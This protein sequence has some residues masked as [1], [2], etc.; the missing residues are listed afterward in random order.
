MHLRKPRVSGFAPIVAVLAM[1]T[2]AVAA[3]RDVQIRTIDF[4]TGVI[5]L[6][7]FGAASQ[8][9]NGFVFCTFDDNQ[10][11][12]YTLSSGLNGQTVAAGASLFIHTLN[13]APAMAGHINR[14]VLGGAMAAPLDA[15]P[16]AMSFYLPPASFT[17]PSHMADHVQWNVGG[18]NVPGLSGRA[19]VAVSAGLW[20]STT[21]WASTTATSTGLE[22]TDESGGLG[23]GPANY[24]AIEDVMTG[25]A[26]CAE[27]VC[28]DVDMASECVPFVCNVFAMLPCSFLGCYGDVDG[29]GSVNA[30][31]RGFIS[32]NIGTSQPDAI[33]LY[34]MDGNAAV[35]AGDRGFVSASIGL[36]QQLPD[37]MDG[38]G[39][40][41]GVPDPRYPAVSYLGD[42]T[43]CAED[44]CP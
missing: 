22:L 25:G 42:G 38:S 3:P 44:D 35:N 24:Q 23:H 12:Q 11:F 33:C 5:E 31:D 14:S 1:T 4:A 34:D 30:G 36:C 21:A 26:C 9:L 6:H 8:S 28:S 39:T 41:G 16:Y 2:A 37:Y 29:N 13:D 17:N 27:G 43:S 32:A 18:A 7:N 40:N 10:T 20:T 15:G 19:T